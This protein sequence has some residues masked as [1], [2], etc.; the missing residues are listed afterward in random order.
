[1]KRLAAVVAAAVVAVTG[2]AGVPAGAAD[3]V[4]SCDLLTRKEITRELGQRARAGDDDLVKGL[5]QWNL[6]ATD[7][8]APGQVNAWVER[9]D[10][11]S[12]QFRLAAQIVGTEPV[13]G[14][15]RKAA[16]NAES[17]TVFVLLD[18]STMFYV[19]VNVYDG[20]QVRLTD[21]LLEHVSALAEK[22]EARL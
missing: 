19:Q 8:R 20:A 12:R 6:V 3:E 5:C 7:D 21:G 1:M 18:G 15:G 16:F 17:G 13:D 22:A 11:A 4:D 9:G 2:V 14:L 10:G